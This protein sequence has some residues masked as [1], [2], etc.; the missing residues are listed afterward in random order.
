MT[1]IRMTGYMAEDRGRDLSGM[2]HDAARNN[3]TIEAV[4]IYL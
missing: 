2:K 4:T 3:L 1:D